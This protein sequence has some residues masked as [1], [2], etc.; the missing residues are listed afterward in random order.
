MADSKWQKPCCIIPLSRSE[1]KRQAIVEAARATFMDKGFDGASMD[2]IAETANV[3]KRTVYNH[4]SSKESLFGDVMLGMCQAKKEMMILEFSPSDDIAQVLKEFGSNFVGG[5]F[6]PDGMALMR[7]L[8]SHLDRFPELGQ[9]FFD[10]GPQEVID[11]V[12]DYFTI[13]TKAGLMRIDK[14]QEA[15]GSFLTSLHG[16]LFLKMLVTT[17]S[18]PEQSQID[19]FVSDAVDRFLHGALVRPT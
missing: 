3:S 9:A 6:D 11:G 1:Q 7:I 14:P 13:Q 18:L 8:V 2:M 15:A 5:I 17:A 10:N 12:A 19:S 16:E 4:Y